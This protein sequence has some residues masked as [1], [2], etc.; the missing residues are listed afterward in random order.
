MDTET[1]FQLQPSSS[2]EALEMLM[3]RRS[4]QSPRD[5]SFVWDRTSEP[6]AH[7]TRTPHGSEIL[8]AI[9]GGPRCPPVGTKWQPVQAHGAGNSGQVQRM[10]RLRHGES[11]GCRLLRFDTQRGVTDI[12]TQQRLVWPG[13]HRMVGG[14][15]HTDMARQGFDSCHDNLLTCQRAQQWQY[16][17]LLGSHC[18][19]L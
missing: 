7:G 16:E 6:E 12:G 10:T 19:T 3:R 15:I 1:Y 8:L 11:R 13:C 14:L 5:R 2:T 17:W 4:G 18:L 9:G